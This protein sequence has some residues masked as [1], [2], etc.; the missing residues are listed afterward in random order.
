MPVLDGVR[1]LAVMLVVL[2]HFFGLKFGWLGVDLFFVLSGFLITG[3]LLDTKNNPS[4]FKN[5]YI[6]RTLRIFP[7]YYLALF[8]FLI[9]LSSS[10]IQKG[11]V[12]S[13]YFFDN[14]IWFI[15]YSQNWLWSFSNWPQD[16]MLNHFWSL[17]VEEQF[18]IFWPLIVYLIPNKKLIYFATTLIII[19]ICTR[20]FTYSSGFSF[21]PLQYVNTFCRL[22]SLSIGA[23]IAIL[24]RTDQI[25]LAKLVRWIIVIIV[26]ITTF[27]I[28]KAQTTKYDNLYYL[29]IGFTFFD[30]LLGA[31]LTICLT[32][33][34]PTLYQLFNLSIMRW[35]GKY[36]YGIYIYHW[37]VFSWLM[38]FVKPF[39]KT[40]L[41]PLPISLIYGI[42]CLATTLLISKI[43]YDYFEAPI[44]KLKNKLTK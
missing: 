10:D 29:T 8:V 34:I 21:T 40:N 33:W 18:Y 7:L 13:N 4:Y 32:N 9:L 31:F 27:I 39:L 23:C 44:L 22:D 16:E 30:L 2:F 37:L 5:F 28:Y 26:P 42:L 20:C 15:T 38:Q 3:I 36:S 11:F 25:L 12:D 41:S 1:G 17:A 24:I 43:S 6:K 19:A 14:A 35:L